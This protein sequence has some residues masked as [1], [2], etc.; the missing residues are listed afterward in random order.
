MCCSSG[1]ATERCS[2]S[3]SAVYLGQLFRVSRGAGQQFY[4]HAGGTLE[5]TSLLQPLMASI[6]N[7]CVNIFYRFLLFAVAFGI[8]VS[9]GL[10]ENKPE[11]QGSDS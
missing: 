7:N 1:G 2:S 6:A 10:A 9:P 4:D 8:S 11:P 5:G 3:N